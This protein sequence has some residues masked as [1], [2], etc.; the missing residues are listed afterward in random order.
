MNEELIKARDVNAKQIL[1]A[2]VA[3]HIQELAIS[4]IGGVVKEAQILMLIVPDGE[5]LE[6]EVFLENKDIGF[7]N[8]GMTAEIKI[9]TFP[10]TKYGIIDGEVITVSDDAT[11]D[12][13]RGLI[14]GMRLLMTKNTLRVNDK[15]VKLIPGM[16]VTA[17]MQI[18]HRRLIEFFMAPL[19]RYRQEGLRER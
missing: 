15:D 4:T 11:L 12:E 6:V 2:P 1:Y 18:G 8:E 10:F 3:G 14:Y 5:H 7:V 9:H 16:A 17:E 19:L 13:K